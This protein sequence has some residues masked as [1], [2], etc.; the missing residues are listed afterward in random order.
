VYAFA[1]C[2]ILRPDEIIF[3]A[4]SKRNP[5]TFPAWQAALLIHIGPYKRRPEDLTGLGS[6][7]LT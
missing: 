4:V 6:G 3:R 5:F 7:R 2:L 1:V